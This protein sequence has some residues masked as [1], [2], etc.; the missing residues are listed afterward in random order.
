MFKL[1]LIIHFL[2]FDSSTSTLTNLNQSTLTRSQIFKRMAF[3]STTW[4]RL[5]YKGSPGLTRTNL[6]CVGH[7][8]A[9]SDLCNVAFFDGEAKQCW[10]AS[11]DNNLTFLSQQFRDIIGFVSVGIG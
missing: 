7:C 2:F 9:A 6:E 1:V 5:V 4:P 11:M 10:L 3:T 8:L